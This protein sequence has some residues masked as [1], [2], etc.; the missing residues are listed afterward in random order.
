MSDNQKH[1]GPGQAPTEGDSAGQQ[2]AQWVAALEE[3]LR[4]YR[5]QGKA[6]RAKQVVEQLRKFKGEGKPRVTRG[7]G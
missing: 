1:A 2:R 7:N 6:D 3:E 4:G 5:Q